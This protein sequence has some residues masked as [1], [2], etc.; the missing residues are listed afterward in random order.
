MHCLP[1][2]MLEAS[3]CKMMKMLTLIIGACSAVV[4]RGRVV[5]IV[6]EIDIS[7]VLYDDYIVNI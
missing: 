4:K 1:T 2:R 6:C 3:R 7:N 5:V